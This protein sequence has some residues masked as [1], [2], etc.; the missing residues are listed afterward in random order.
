MLVDMEDGPVAETIRSTYQ[1]QSGKRGTTSSSNN[2]KGHT[3]GD[4]TSH[5]LF[6]ARQAITSVEGG[7][8]GNNF[9]YGHYVCGPDHE[10]AVM[11]S[12]M[13][14]AERRVWCKHIQLTVVKRSEHCARM[15]T[16]VM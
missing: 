5:G 16:F 15:G 14:R 2:A 3:T 7:G 13:T 1:Q 4:E 11:V 12:L 8:A 10:D 6:E 9:A